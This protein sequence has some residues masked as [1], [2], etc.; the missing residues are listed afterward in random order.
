MSVGCI[1]STSQGLWYVTLHASDRARERAGVE[2]LDSFLGIL[3]SS[4]LVKLTSVERTSY[5]LL[6]IPAGDFV[7]AVRDPVRDPDPDDGPGYMALPSLVT[8]MHSCHGI[9]GVSK[10]C[11]ARAM[12]TLHGKDPGA[13]WSMSHGKE[14]SKRSAVQ[15]ARRKREDALEDDCDEE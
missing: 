3:S 5:Y 8:L 7:L 9:L 4:R 2:S 11:L 13:R 1:A 12:D 14:K 15:H 10:T 6:G